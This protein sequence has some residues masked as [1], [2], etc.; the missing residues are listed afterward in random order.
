MYPSDSTP[1]RLAIVGSGYSGT[2]VAVHLLRQPQPV[3]IDLIDT[4]LPGRGLAYSTIWNHHLLNV[5][6]GRMSAFAS[7]PGHFLDWLK[8]HAH[9]DVQPESFIPRNTFGAYIQDILQ[10]VVHSAPS[11]H[12]LRYFASQAIRVT[13]S[14]GTAQILLHNGEQ[15]TAD[16]MVLASGN[17]APRPVQAASD[18]YFHSPWQPGAMANVDPNG[19]VLLLGSGLT[20]IDAFLALRAQGHQ[21]SVI[22]L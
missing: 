9:P 7:E 20:A 14:G 2:L 8:A 17:P 10:S 13:Y 16:R 4:R 5:P 21:G 22:C 12:R 1:L 15:L 18:R 6:A 19:T 3:H 11:K